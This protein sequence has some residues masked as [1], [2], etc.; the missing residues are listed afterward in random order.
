[1]KITIEDVKKKFGLTNEDLKRLDVNAI[2]GLIQNNKKR[3]V[4]HLRYFGH[5][6]KEAVLENKYL[7]CLLE[8]AE[9]KGGIK[10]VK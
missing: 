6:S 9:R 5:D 2:K 7:T 10:N 8:Y 1:M 3:N 4:E